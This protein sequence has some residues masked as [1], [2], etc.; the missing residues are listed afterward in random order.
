MS[1][2]KRAAHSYRA[3]AAVPA[4]A[5]DHPLI[6]FDGQCVLCSA[7][8]RFV[9]RHDRERRYRFTAAQSPLGQALY[10]HYGLDPMTFETNLLIE[11]GVGYGKIEAF[12]RVARRLGWPW[13]AGIMLGLLPRRVA[14]PLYDLIARNRYRLFGQAQACAVPDASWRD[15]IIG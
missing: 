7:F 9:A 6:V 5:D 11:D 15:R 13:R 8:A 14:D 2:G 1:F 4:F 10:R 3:D 12:A